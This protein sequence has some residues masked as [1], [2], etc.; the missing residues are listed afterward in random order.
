MEPRCIWP[1]GHQQL[2]LGHGQELLIMH[3]LHHLVRYCSSHSM[4]GSYS[5]PE[6]HQLRSPHPLTQH[7]ESPPSESP[8]CPAAH[9]CQAY[10][11]MLSSLISIV[12]AA[13]AAARAGCLGS[14][15]PTASSDSMAVTS[16][17]PQ[18]QVNVKVSA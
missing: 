17:L 10:H 3:H 6:A 7:P 15:H 11:P 13:M 8:S 5:T 9:H 2:V 12:V 16:R 18:H 4:I 1:S 14:P